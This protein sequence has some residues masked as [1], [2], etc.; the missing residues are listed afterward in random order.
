MIF[1]KNSS[2]VST[3]DW[4]DNINFDLIDSGQQNK[5]RRESIYKEWSKFSYQYFR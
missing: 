4:H 2:F 3:I 1:G 5:Q